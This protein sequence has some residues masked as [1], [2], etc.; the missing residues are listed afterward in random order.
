M[1]EN[2]TPKEPDK[3]VSVRLTPT[4]LSDWPADD[5]SAPQVQTME[6]NRTDVAEP[7]GSTT[8]ES[9]RHK[10]HVT[11]VSHNCAPSAARGVRYYGTQ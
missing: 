4:V 3:D 11:T 9:Q 6:E 8:K 10:S 5:A 1:S 2:P 7:S